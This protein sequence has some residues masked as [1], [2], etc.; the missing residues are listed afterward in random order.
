MIRKDVN[1]P[2]YARMPPRTPD[3]RTYRPV[4]TD[5]SD[6]PRLHQKP[7]KFW[8]FGKCNWGW[9]CHYLHG[10]TLADDPRRPEYKGQAIDFTQF[11][12]PVAASHFSPQNAAPTEDY[13]KAKPLRNPTVEVIVTNK[14]CFPL[15]T[16]IKNIC[17]QNYI[18]ILYYKSTPNDLFYQ[19]PPEKL[20]SKIES[21]RSDFI[22]Y[23]DSNNLTL[24]PDSISITQQNLA[25]VIHRRWDIL[26]NNLTV[27]QIELLT[28]SDLEN[29]ITN[30]TSL[31]NI[32]NTVEEFQNQTANF[33]SSFSLEECRATTEELQEFR[34]QLQ[35]FFGRLNLAN[36]VIAEM[37]L[38]GSTSSQQP[39]VVLPGS[40]PPSNG[41]SPPMQRALSFTIAT[42]LTQMHVCLMHINKLLN[43]FSIA[44]TI[45]ATANY[46]SV[47]MHPTPLCALPFASMCNDNQQRYRMANSTD[48]DQKLE[49][50]VNVEMRARYS[51]NFRE[52]NGFDTNHFNQFLQ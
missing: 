14:L 37:Q 31:E 52:Q 25:D 46:K 44:Q 28:S 21:K 3:P 1:N 29:I 22:I 24:Y 41:L 42:Y 4:I 27:D 18:N 50:D 36:S 16:S 20:K 26:N 23:V 13:S 6:A 7:C 51:I 38:F 40:L 39:G 48:Y 34:S 8:K 49:T 10:N 5:D 9:G 47:A 2:Q 32:S 33:L 19:M 17:L 11:P 35:G 43:E 12:R 15:A 45:F 30:L